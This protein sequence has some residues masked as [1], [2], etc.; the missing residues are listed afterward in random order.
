MSS[1]N[2]AFK[3]HSSCD[4]NIHDD[5]KHLIGSFVTLILVMQLYRV[6]KIYFG[7]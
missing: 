4:I 1:P 6:L 3:L 7:N 2:T 5:F